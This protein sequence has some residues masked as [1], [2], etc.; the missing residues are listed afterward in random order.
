MDAT[1]APTT[2]NWDRGLQFLMRLHKMNDYIVI[3]SKQSWERSWL[4]G[5][6]V[7]QHGNEQEWKHLMCTGDHPTPGIPP[8]RRAVAPTKS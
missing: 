5:Q 7:L 6:Q 1:Y 3:I 8:P 4:M 2:L